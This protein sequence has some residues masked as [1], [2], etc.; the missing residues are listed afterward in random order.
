MDFYVFSDRGMLNFEWSNRMYERDTA[1]VHALTKTFNY[2]R[3]GLHDD[4]GWDECIPYTSLSDMLLE[5]LDHSE[6]LVV[7]DQ[8]L[9]DV[10]SCHVPVEEKLSEKI[11]P[12]PKHSDELAKMQWLWVQYG[13]DLIKFYDAYQEILVEPNY[14]LLWKVELD[15]D[16]LPLQGVWETTII[17]HDATFKGY[18]IIYDGRDHFVF[19][20]KSFGGEGVHIQLGSKVYRLRKMW[21]CYIMLNLEV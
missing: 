19:A 21:P 16:V 18:A 20:P 2:H 12:I 8:A 17:K 6:E 13:D 10:I 9:Y 1:E 14:G 7:A 4:S 15:C 11:K 5:L 3:L